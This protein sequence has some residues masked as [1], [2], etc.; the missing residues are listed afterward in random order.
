MFLKNLSI[1]KRKPIPDSPP[2]CNCLPR[3]AGGAPSAALRATS[4]NSYKTMFVKSQTPTR[5]CLGPSHELQPRR[6]AFPF[7][8]QHVNDRRPTVTAC[9]PEWCSCRSA[10]SREICTLRC[11]RRLTPITVL[12]LRNFQI[13]ADQGLKDCNK[14]LNNLHLRQGIDTF[15]HSV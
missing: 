14:H 6:S 12:Q 11:F 8:E 5:L 15:L 7:F 2:A 9:A 10:S 4:C 13:V 1:L 3:N